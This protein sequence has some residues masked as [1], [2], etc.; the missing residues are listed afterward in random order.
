MKYQ[1]IAITAIRSEYGGEEPYSIEHLDVYVVWAC[2]ILGNE[3][4]LISTNVP[5]NR[6]YE[7]TVDVKDKK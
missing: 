6:Y 5:D 7:V 3:K 4:Y 2:Y 1:E